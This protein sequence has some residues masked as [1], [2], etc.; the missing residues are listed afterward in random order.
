Y[1][2]PV[3]STMILRLVIKQHVSGKRYVVLLLG[4]C[5][6]ALVLGADSSL[7]LPSHAGEWMG[8]AGGLTW[9]IMS[10]T[11]RER[12]PLHPVDGSFAFVLGG[13]LTLA[14]LVAVMPPVAESATGFSLPDW[15]T[16]LWILAAAGIWWVG[17][18]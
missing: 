5:G 3:W 6:L 17:T 16:L 1:L 8:L 14:L 18:V 13:L 15:H 4:L 7:P 12:P 11:V 2:T 9:A 10:V